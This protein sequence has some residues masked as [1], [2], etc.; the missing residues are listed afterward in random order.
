MTRLHELLSSS[1]AK[2]WIEDTAL[3]FLFLYAAFGLGEVRQHLHEACNRVVELWRGRRF[4]S[5]ASTGLS[6]ILVALG[7]LYISLEAV[8]RAFA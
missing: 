1:Q 5:L 2:H 7:P 8:Q 6:G 3:V 4:A